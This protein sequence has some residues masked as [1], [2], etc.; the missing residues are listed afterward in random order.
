MPENEN[1]QCGLLIVSK[2]IFLEKKQKEIKRLR[3]E[4][5]G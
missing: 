2:V 1:L 5:I 4:E 3:E